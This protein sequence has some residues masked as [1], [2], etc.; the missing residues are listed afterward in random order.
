MRFVTWKEIVQ[1]KLVP[2]SRQ[3]FE[4]LVRRGLA[5]QKRKRGNRTVWVFE[6]LVDWQQKAFQPVRPTGSS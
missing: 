5:P 1:L 4:R 6:E 3:H 2:Y